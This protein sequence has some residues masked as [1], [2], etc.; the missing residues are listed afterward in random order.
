MW[1]ESQSAACPKTRPSSVTSSAVGPSRI[2]SSN[3]EVGGRSITCATSR[4]SP[5]RK[6][7]TARSRPA[8]A[9]RNSSSTGLP[10]ST[11]GP[12]RGRR[13]KP[14]VTRARSNGMPSPEAS[15]SMEASANAGNAQT[16]APMIEASVTAKITLPS[17]S[18]R[19]SSP[20]SSPVSERSSNSRI[21]RS[22]L[23]PVSISSRTSRSISIPKS[24]G[25][26]D[27]LPDHLVRLRVPGDLIDP[28]G[29]RRA[30]VPTGA[31]VG[32]RHQRER[33]VAPV[34]SAGVDQTAVVCLD[35]L[36][37]EDGAPACPR[38][39]LGGRHLVIGCSSG[40]GHRVGRRGRPAEAVIAVVGLGVVELAG[41]DRLGDPTGERGADAREVVVT[42]RD[43]LVRLR[44]W[45]A[46]PPSLP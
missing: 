32:H 30:L 27:A 40:R 43:A 12:S 36:Q 25:V 28:S 19:A 31:G 16:V 15:S 33:Q 38:Q 39:F 8:R 34:E 23:T 11:S 21:A 13:A 1:Q 42:A 9:S 46:P 17:S 7:S 6:V 26:E 20:S 22:T 44:H 14:A 18:N 41:D 37:H 5:S 2:G 4:E 29:D 3:Q 10:G 45:R 24:P 35:S